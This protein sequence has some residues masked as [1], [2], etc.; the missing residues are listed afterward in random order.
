MTEYYPA[1][2]GQYLRIF[3]NFQNFVCCEKDLMDNKHNSLHF[4][5]KYAPILVLG[6]YLFLVPS[7]IFSCQVEAIVIYTKF[8]VIVPWRQKDVIE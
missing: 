3:A 8:R 7:S 6:H 5:R 4:G 2:T 1:K